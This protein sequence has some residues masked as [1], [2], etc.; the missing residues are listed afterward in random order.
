VLVLLGVYGLEEFEYADEPD[1]AV[2]PCLKGL[3]E[4]AVCPNFERAC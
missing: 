1:E 3:G 2:E 4:A